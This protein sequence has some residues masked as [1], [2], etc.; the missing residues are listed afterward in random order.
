MGLIQLG[1]GIAQR[2]LE[3]VAQA[4]GSRGVALAL[5]IVGAVAAGFGGGEGGAGGGAARGLER[6]AEAPAAPQA[7]A[8][9]GGEVPRAVPGEIAAPRL[10]Q[11][12]PAPAFLPDEDRQAAVN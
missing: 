2:V 6:I 7:P 8:A 10:G 3:I 5:A 1:L 12:A 9:P 4:T 11:A